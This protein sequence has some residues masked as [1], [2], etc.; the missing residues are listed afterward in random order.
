MAIEFERKKM[1]LQW[2]W[3]VKGVLLC[4]ITVALMLSQPAGAE[5][6]IYYPIRV[7]NPDGLRL[8]FVKN[9]NREG[10]L[11]VYGKVRRSTL[12]GRVATTIHVSITGLDGSIWQAQSVNY[13]PRTISRQR[14]HDEARFSARFEGIPQQGAVIRVGQAK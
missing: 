3:P 10:D 14:R 8:F 2:K 13:S 7:E 1:K 9:D 4:I 6:G 12:P 5:N 11:V